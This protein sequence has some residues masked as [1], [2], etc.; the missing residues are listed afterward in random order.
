MWH[1]D[2]QPGESCAWQ[3]H[4]ADYLTIV[5]RALANYFG[6]SL[7]SINAS[8]VGEAFSGWDPTC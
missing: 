2:L 8:S 5:Q 4:D 6:A 3:A 1:L 7:C